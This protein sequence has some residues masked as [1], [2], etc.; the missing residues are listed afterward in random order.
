[1]MIRERRRRTTQTTASR[2]SLVPTLNQN[3]PADI[4]HSPS[5]P[6]LDLQNVNIS[7]FSSHR[8]VLLPFRY[9]GLKHTCTGFKQRNPVIHDC[10]SNVT[11]KIIC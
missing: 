10:Q 3:N 6:V 11:A 7:L 4:P 5:P 8:H 2:P 1:M 9:K